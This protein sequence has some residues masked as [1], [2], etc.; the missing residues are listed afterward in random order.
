MKV[1]CLNTMPKNCAF[2]GIGEVV[3]LVSGPRTHSCVLPSWLIT[4][5]SQWLSATEMNEF[6]GSLRVRQIL[7]TNGEFDAC[8][9]KTKTL[10]AA[11]CFVIAGDAPV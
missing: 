9:S 8:F 2:L 7:S 11:L 3:A 5:I 6:T 4:T 1:P 10:S